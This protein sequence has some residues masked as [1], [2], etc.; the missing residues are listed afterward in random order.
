MITRWSPAI[1]WTAFSALLLLLTTEHKENFILLAPLA[2]ISAVAAIGVYR[3]RARHFETLAITRSFG[4]KVAAD[5]SMVLGA[6]LTPKG[7]GT[8]GAIAALPL[9]YL[10]ARLEPWEKFPT[11]AV[12]T[13]LSVYATH[14][15]LQYEKRVLDPKEVV[16]DELVGVSI[17]IAFVPWTLVQ[18]AGAFV[19]F[20]IFDITKP[21]PIGWLE[22]RLPG[23]WGVM[24]DDVAAGLVAGLIMVAFNYAKL[25][26]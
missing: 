14:R 4:A 2:L 22:H 17:A 3:Q 8:V 6:G 5:A 25:H 23:A 7:S 11:L 1:F 18:V 24:M 20:R 16:V 12:L 13:L 15:Y 19:L 21:G 10:L 9:T 26:L